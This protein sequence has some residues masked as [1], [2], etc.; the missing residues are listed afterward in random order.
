MAS[1]VALDGLI[2]RGDCGVALQPSQGSSLVMA[3]FYP[4]LTTG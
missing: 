3:K 1:G 4:G 2:R